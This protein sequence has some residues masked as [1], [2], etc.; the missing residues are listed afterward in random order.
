MP[1]SVDTDRLAEDLPKIMQQALPHFQASDLRRD[2]TLR[3]YGLKADMQKEG[4]GGHYWIMTGGDVVLFASSQVPPAE[5]DVWNPPF[6]QLMASL[7][8]TREDALFMRKLSIEVLEK[9]REQHP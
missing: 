1:M 2:E 5:R 9:L 3:H 6:E 4:E 7:Q 8:I